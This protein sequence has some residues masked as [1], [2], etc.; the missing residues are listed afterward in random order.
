M[1]YFFGLFLVYDLDDFNFFT[2]SGLVRVGDLYAE[3]ERELLLELRVPITSNEGHHVLSVCCSYKDPATQEIIYG[4]D[5]PLLVPKPQQFRSSLPKIQRLR[6]FF[7]TTR[8]IAES[9]RLIS[10]NE[11]SSAVQLLASSRELLVQSGCL[12]EEY[13]RRLEAELLEIKWRKEAEE[14]M[15]Q[16]R[17][18]MVE[19]KEEALTPSSAWRG[20]DRLGKV[21]C[22][23]KSA[24]R[25][26]DLHGFEN[27]R[28]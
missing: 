23:K 25:V 5:Q 4:T 2:R 24:K 18:R 13:V 11:M 6:N 27:A 12:G 1:E 16:R 3:E 15:M 8:A 19:D 17:Q 28:F 20:S 10:L 14:E 22:G 7:I 9:R 21:S 26:S